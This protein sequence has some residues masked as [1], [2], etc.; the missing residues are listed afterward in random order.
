M[1]S[2]IVPF[3]PDSAPFSSEQRAWLNGFLAGMFSRSSMPDMGTQMPAD[4]P[5][6]TIVWGSQTGNAEGLARKAKKALE[7]G[8]AEVEVFDLGEYSLDRL[9]GEKNLIV[10]TSTYGEGEPPDNALDFYNGIAEEKAPRVESMRFAVLALGD[11]SYPDFCEFGKFVDVRLEQ[12]GGT[13]AFDRVDCD[14]DF[15]DPF[16]AWLQSV[17][18][19]FAANEVVQESDPGEISA[20][21]TEAVY[22]KKN[23]FPA[24]LL[25]NL[26]LN[27]D[28]SAKDTR[29]LEFSL[30]GSGL[31]YE[32]GDALGVVPKNAPELV[33]RLMSELGFEPADELIESL[34]SHYDIC[35]LSLPLLE[36]LAES[37]G[38][39]LLEEKTVL[40]KED[41]AA[42]QKYIRGRDVLDVIEEFELRWPDPASFLAVLKPTAPRLYSISSSPKAHPDEVHLTV[43]V[44]GYESLGRARGGVCSGFLARSEPESSVS[45]YVQPNKHFKPPTDPGLPMIM[46]GP[47]TGIAPFRAFLE[48]RHAVGASGSNWLFFGDQKESLDFLYREE[49]EGMREA[50][51]L[52][53]L[54]LAFSRDQKEKIYVQHRMMENA[55]E[56]WKWLEEGA[57]FYV[58]G[59]ASRMAKDVD[60]ALHK[61]IEIAGEKSEE[62]ARE[63]V[64]Q[65][66]SSKRYVRDVY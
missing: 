44:V 14:V 54:D 1:N 6:V 33:S 46:V 47:G 50:G 45:V 66:S 26:K 48:E 23:P 12:L 38:C 3:I 13:R 5:K 19:L 34:E 27:G 8:G 16:E 35:K 55:A 24:P 22:S 2:P 30:K 62:E 53:R 15:E 11:T 7:A 49:L 18:P 64:K 32:V 39:G 4:R 43:G 42:F 51:L 20:G 41:R 21:T 61:V 10:I 40:F 25:T 56:L 29:H 28:G 59:D 52:T 9:N 31:V 60:A 37:A 36:Q 65:L 63:Y 58:C 57:H 17:T